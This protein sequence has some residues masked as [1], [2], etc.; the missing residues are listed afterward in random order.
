[1][2]MSNE[3]NTKL[4][5]KQTVLKP[6]YIWG[7]TLLILAIFEIDSILQKNSIVIDLLIAFIFLFLGLIVYRSTQ[8]PGSFTRKVSELGFWKATGQEL[9]SV[10]SAKKA[11]DTTNSRI[12]RNLC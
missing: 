4:N 11:R 8:K 6:I 3:S 5:Q 12:K 10:F 9:V 7:V 2:K 1:M